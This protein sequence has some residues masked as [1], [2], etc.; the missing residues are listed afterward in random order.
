MIHGLKSKPNS[1][2]DN[3]DRTRAPA[4]AET[5]NTDTLQIDFRELLKPGGVS[6]G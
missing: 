2:K 4:E 5:A 3:E 1:G 6:G